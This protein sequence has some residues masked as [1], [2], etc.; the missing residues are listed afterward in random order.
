MAEPLTFE[1]N[2]AG[3]IFKH[4]LQVHLLAQFATST[5]IGIGCTPVLS[6]E[7]SI[8]DRVSFNY[9]K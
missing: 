1:N 6:M 8:V 9:I 7:G 4:T 3:L 5:E 2:N